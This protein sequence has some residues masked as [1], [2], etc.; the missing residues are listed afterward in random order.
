VI[1]KKNKELKGTIGKDLMTTLFFFTQRFFILV[2]LTEKCQ[3]DYTML[4]VKHIQ[5][6]GFTQV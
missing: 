6:L 3:T 1:H 4:Q 5:C 2:E